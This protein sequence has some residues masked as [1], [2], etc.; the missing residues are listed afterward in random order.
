MLGQS[1][2]DSEQKGRVRAT[3]IL[4]SVAL[5]VTPFPFELEITRRSIVLGDNIKFLPAGYLKFWPIGLDSVP[6][7]HTLQEGF[8][9]ETV[10][11]VVTTQRCVINL[12]I[13]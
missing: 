9:L 6:N 3:I 8:M 11:P 7:S 5:T 2:L 13:I 12:H 1:V 10:A 4:T